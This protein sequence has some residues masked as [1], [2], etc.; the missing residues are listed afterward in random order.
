MHGNLLIKKYDMNGKNVVKAWNERISKSEELVRV[1]EQAKEV[2]GM[3]DRYIGSE[4]SRG[5]FDDILT[6]LCTGYTQ[7]R[8]CNITVVLVVV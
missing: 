6:Y 8:L 3:K 1:C 7:Q 4:M 5:E 2:V